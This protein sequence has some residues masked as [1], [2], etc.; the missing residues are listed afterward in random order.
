V[1]RSRLKTHFFLCLF[2]NLY[3]YVQC[4]RGDFCHFGHFNRFLCMYVCMYV[5]SHKLL[6]DCCNVQ[7]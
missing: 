1:F 6:K 2:L 4:L 3:L 7:K 5:T